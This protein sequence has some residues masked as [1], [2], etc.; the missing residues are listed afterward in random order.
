MPIFELECLNCGHTGEVLVL[1]SNAP[2]QCPGCG[3]DQTRKL[4]SA[5][6]SLTGRSPQKVPGPSDTTCCGNR[7]GETGCAGPGSCCGQG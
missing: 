2:I 7:P 1:D 4:I 5:T 6:S 3:S